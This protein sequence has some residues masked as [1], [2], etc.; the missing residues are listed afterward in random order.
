MIDTDEN[1][2]ERREIRM[3]KVDEAARAVAALLPFPAPLEADM[4]GTFT[5][6]IDLGCRGG[7]DDPH[8]M[9]G[10]DPDYEPLVWMI[11]INGGEYQIT[12]PHDLDTDP[13]TVAQWITEHARAARCPA[14]TTQR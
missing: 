14:A 2:D 5:F 11:D 13:A 3:D 10:I 12:A 4:G 7:Q 1:L 9:V 8:D 6:Q